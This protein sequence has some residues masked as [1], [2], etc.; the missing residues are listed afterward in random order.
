MF[1]ISQTPTVR[2]G[3]PRRTALPIIA[4]IL[5]TLT[6]CASSALLPHSSHRAA[7]PTS[8]GHG[9]GNQIERGQEAVGIAGGELPDH[10]TVFNQTYPGITRL[11]SA[12]LAALRT[13]ARDA[14]GE[15]VE[16][17]VNSGWR[18]HGY[19]EQLF[20]QAVATYGSPGRAAQWAARPGTSRHES[21]DA[22][23]LGPT[24]ADDWLSRHGAAYGLC[25]IYRNEPWHYE[26]RPDAADQGCPDMYA[27]AAQ[28]P[29]L[30]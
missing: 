11:D 12:L 30:Q 24:R 29:R 20:G 8:S 15:G 7:W 21:G 26:L 23:D 18:S 17:Y 19:Q 10:V 25:Q 9:S 13:A 27:T 2:H 22:V 3:T 28:D 4:L 5:V 14:R 1:V 6:A 16:F